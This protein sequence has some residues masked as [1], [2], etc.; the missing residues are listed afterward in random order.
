MQTNRKWVYVFW[1]GRP[2]AISDVR[3]LSG[4]KKSGLTL[5]SN[6]QSAIGSLT[7]NSPVKNEKKKK[8]KNRFFFRPRPFVPY[9]LQF[10][11]LPHTVAYM[12]S[13]KRRFSFYFQMSSKSGKYPQLL[14]L[15]R[16]F[17]F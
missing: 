8:G 3:Y 14:I 9:K 17:F 5:C 1:L 15:Q 10:L 13:I 2:E 7:V 6:F 16:D 12:E 11:R 4:E